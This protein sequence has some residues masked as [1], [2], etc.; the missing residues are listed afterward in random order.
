MSSVP[1]T[2][3]DPPSPCCSPLLFG[4]EI[5]EAQSL[6]PDLSDLARGASGRFATGSFGWRHDEFC[7]T[8]SQVEI[9]RK[10]Q[11]K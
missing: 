2:V 7:V 5:E 10:F 6:G 9:S 3:A 4:S 1:E 11:P 8:Q